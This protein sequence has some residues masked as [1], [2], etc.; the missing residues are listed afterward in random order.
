MEKEEK[1]IEILVLPANQSLN[2]LRRR[3]MLEA[4]QQALAMFYKETRTSRAADSRASNT[5]NVAAAK[6]NRMTEE[7]EAKAM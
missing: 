6:M 2:L 7:E 3:R 5:S 4:R 1:D